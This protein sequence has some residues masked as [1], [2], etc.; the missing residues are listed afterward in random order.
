MAVAFTH[1]KGYVHGDLY[2]GNVLLQLTSRLNHLSDQQL[3]E[4]F[5]SPDPK[6][7]T[8]ADGKPLTSGVPSHVFSP[9]KPVLSDF[10]VAFSPVR[11][12]RSES[13]TPL[14]MRPPEA[15]FESNT[16]LSFA[17]NIWSLG[18]AIW[19]I[20]AQRSFLDSFLFSEDDATGDQVVA[21]GPL[22]PEEF[23]ANGR[24]REDRVVWSWY[25]RF[26]DSIQQPRRESGIEALDE[27]ERDAFS[28][29]V[30]SMLLF[31]PR[32]RP[33]ARQILNSMD[34]MLGDSRI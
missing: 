18:C 19:A 8:R 7:V 16:P 15:R 21:L 11:E 26:E 10:G 27:K 32:D 29:M 4:E 2:L 3:Y 5:G 17:S 1:D 28:E 22:P 6:L 24:P 14:Q 33:N 30:R 25:Q 13:Y 34:E 31:K 12:S 20:L 9:A 23:I